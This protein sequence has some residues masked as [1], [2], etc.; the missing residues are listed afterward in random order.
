MSATVVISPH[1]DDAVLSAWLVLDAQ[2]G[3]EVVSCFAGIPPEGVIGLWDSVTG[4]SSP[5]QVMMDRRMEDQV[6]LAS[7]KSTHVHLDLLDEQYRQGRPPPSVQLATLLRPCIADA[8]DVWLPAG[9]GQHRDHVAVRDAGLAAIAHTE[10][11]IHLYGDLPY[12][13]QPAWPAFVAPGCRHF[14]R[15]LVLQALGRPQSELLWRSALDKADLDLAVSDLVVRKLT[16]KEWRAKVAAVRKY[17]SQLQALKCG[18][19]HPLRERTLFAYEVY[20]DLIN[21]EVQSRV[22]MT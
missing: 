16:R 12:A 10:Q 1:L 19:K 17:A 6:A 13:A 22:V 5:S 2:P 3:T 7:T 20:W 21:K 4:F 9:L 14:V 18:P 8:Q 11:R 15:R